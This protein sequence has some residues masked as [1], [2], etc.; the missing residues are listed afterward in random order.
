M[1]VD[2]R[3]K[4]YVWCLGKVHKITNKYQEK[5]MKYV[6]IKFGSKK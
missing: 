1:Q 3:D 2:I 4:D 6:V 5:K